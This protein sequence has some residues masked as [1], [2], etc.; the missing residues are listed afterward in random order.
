MIAYC[1]LRSLYIISLQGYLLVVPGGSRHLSLL[2]NAGV[3]NIWQ[4]QERKERG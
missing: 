3:G 2:T 1:S 4:P